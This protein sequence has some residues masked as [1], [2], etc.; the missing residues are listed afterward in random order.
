MIY[1]ISASRRNLLLVPKGGNLKRVTVT[2]TQQKFLCESSVKVQPGHS[3]D[4]KGSLVYVVWCKN[5]L[6]LPYDTC[7]LQQTEVAFTKP[8]CF[9]V[10]SCATRGHLKP[11]THFAPSACTLLFQGH[12]RFLSQLFRIKV[13]RVWLIWLPVCASM[14]GADISYML[15]FWLACFSIT[16]SACSTATTCLCGDY[17]NIL[18]ECI[19][20]WYRRAVRKAKKFSP[21]SINT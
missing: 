20:K 16:V 12:N 7:R 4:S 6:Y 11:T 2:C 8:N 17:L 1:Y 10:N 18:D 13:G 19:A 3:G 9:H 15:Q 5:I 21:T 14:E